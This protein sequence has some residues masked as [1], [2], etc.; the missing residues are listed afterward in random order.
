MIKFKFLAIGC[1]IFLMHNLFAQNGTGTGVVIGQDSARRVIT[2]AVP[3]LLISP[4]ARASAMGDVGATTSPDANSSHWNPAKLSFINKD[5][6]FSLSY[7]PWLN[8]IV[9]DMSISYL[10]GYKRISKTQVVGASI[11]YFDLGDIQLRDETGE[12][13]GQFNP[14]EFEFMG[15][16]SQV[17]TEKLSIGANAKFIYSN[18]SGNIAVLNNDTKPGT[19]VALDFGL[20]YTSDLLV[21]SKESKLTFASVISNIGN[22]ITYNS[23]E[24]RDFLPTNLRLGTAFTSNL[25]P[26]NSI[27]F[28]LELNKLLV[29]T[30]PIV[31]SNGQITSGK[32]P[33]RSLLSGI[34]GSFSD[35]P[36]GFSEELKEFII[37]FG[38]EYWY[39]KV[40]AARAGYFYENPVKGDR[41]Y[42]TLGLGLRYQKFGL[43]VAYLVPQTR[44]HPLA[45]TLRFSLVFNI[46]KE[47]Q[48]AVTED[49]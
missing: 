43:D 15:T 23:S 31:D 4:D 25:D 22:K 44:E 8:K 21:G 38:V 14:R 36:D 7:T 49:Q 35:A 1:L 41:K 6:G 26:Y 30:P 2:T 27:T 24:N 37:N 19:A 11:R 5:I 47:N 9:N 13:T 10:S 33:D 29:P 12:A 34:F 40:F 42:F 46:E 20:Y 48:D 18:L 45:E 32:N 16:F 17:L 3:F 39:N 28:A